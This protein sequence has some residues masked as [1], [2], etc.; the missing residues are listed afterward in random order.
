MFAQARGINMHYVIDGPEN[1][2]LVTFITGI[3]NDVTLWEAQ[4][5]AL[6]SNFR[7]MRYDLRGQGKSE[8]TPGPYS[9]ASLGEDLIALWDAIGVRKSHLVGLGLGGSI[10]IGVAINHGDRLLSVAPTCCRARMEP[11]F[12]VMW[13]KLYA[14]VR[15]NG[16]ESIVEQTAQ[17]WFTDEFKAAHPDVIDKVR[18]MI[19]STTQAGYL[20]VVDAFLKLDVIDEMH[21]IKVPATFMG[22][23][24]DKSGGPPHL[25]AA[26]A[27]KIPGAKYTPISRAAHIANVQN[28]EEFSRVLMD[29][30]IQQPA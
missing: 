18:A 13:H 6:S 19:R 12:A 3:A 17:R 8:A 10:A 25:M 30:L 9:I 26:L 4:A 11:D 20:G 5:K 23:A 28:P 21:R 7:V 16:V 14:N 22:G 1:A 29:F 15:D 2:P 24:D 27:A